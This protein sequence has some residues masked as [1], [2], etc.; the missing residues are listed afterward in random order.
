MI[1]G[2]P[3]SGKSTMLSELIGDIASRRGFITREVVK[4]QRRTGFE[5][6]DMSNRRAILA[7]TDN[8]TNLQVER[9]YVQ[10]KI[11]AE[12]TKPLSRMEAGEFLYIDEIG[13]M[14]LHSTE[15][16]TL[17][18]KYLDAPNDFA[19]TITSV[20]SDELTERI[21]ARNDILFFHLTEESRVRV[22]E[23]LTNALKNK[24]MFNKLSSN[25]QAVVIGSANYYLTENSHVSF[26][27]LFSNAIKYFLEN[28]VRIVG[29]DNYV[30]DGNTYSH[31][32]SSK[33]ESGWRCDCPLSNGKEP[34][35]AP[36]DCS[37]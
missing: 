18:E 10:P 3:K 33:S 26:G 29:P 15:F 8:P 36:T 16:K 22:K 35:S 4:D 20:Y 1:S 25:L 30:V 32:V 23:S 7:Q 6:I 31:H 13:Q 9:F 21:L 37:H 27:K 2:R 5:V 19:A 17:V 34:F 24:G 14:Q 12:F 28:K 11:L